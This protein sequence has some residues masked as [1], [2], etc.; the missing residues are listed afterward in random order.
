MERERL[1]VRSEVL[2]RLMED[3]E[4]IDLIPGADNCAFGTG[5]KFCSKCAYVDVGITCALASPVAFLFPDPPF[6]GL[7]LGIYT[8]G[9][10]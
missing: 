8:P 10:R 6:S 3:R 7:P 2:N 4:G 5:G 1:C 9:E